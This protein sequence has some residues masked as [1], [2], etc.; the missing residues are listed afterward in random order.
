MFRKSNL[1]FALAFLSGIATAQDSESIASIFS[2]QGLTLDIVS[3]SKDQ[4]TFAGISQE[5]SSLIVAQKKNGN[6]KL[7][8]KIDSSLTEGAFRPE[9]FSENE[10]LFFSVYDASSFINENKSFLLRQNNMRRDNCLT[11]SNYSNFVM[12]SFENNPRRSIA[13]FGYYRPQRFTPYHRF[14]EQRSIRR[15]GIDIKKIDKT[16]DLFTESNAVVMFTDNFSAFI[17]LN[18]DG[19]I[20]SENE[21]QLKAPIFWSNKG[22]GVVKDEVTNEYYIFTETNFSYNWYSLNSETG[23][24]KFITKMNEVWEN[25]NFRIEDGQLY[26]Q[27]NKSGKLENYSYNLKK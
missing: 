26:Y 4:S 21:I 20:A 2:N 11:C 6:Y 18:L 13:T 12:N 23:A 24:T 16:V 15:V 25:P 3:A 14:N 9:G 1:L 19:T 5:T 22:R 27:K 8:L 17:R 7:P 10:Y